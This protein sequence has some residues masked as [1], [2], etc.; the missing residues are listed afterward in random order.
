MSTKD[1]IQAKFAEIKQ[2]WHET[3]PSKRRIIMAV[4]FISIISMVIFYLGDKREKE[5]EQK[6]NDEVT[7]KD[8]IQTNNLVQ[9]NVGEVGIDDLI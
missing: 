6:A 4:V 7:V 8:E 9:P 3:D 1:Q 5:N 2:Q